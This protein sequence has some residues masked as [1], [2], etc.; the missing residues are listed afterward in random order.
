MITHPLKIAILGGGVFGR[1]HIQKA[2]GYDK[3]GHICLFEPDKARAQAM[4]DEF[5]IALMPTAQAAIDHC[6]AVVI[7]APAIH[8]AEL[9]HAALSAG[10]HCLIEKPIAH[11]L[12]DAQAICDMA[13]EKGLTVHMGHQERYVLAAIGI[14]TIVPKPRLIEMFRENLFSERGTDVSAT[15]DLTVHDLD[16]VMWLLDAQPLGIMATGDVV[17]TSYIDQ[18]RAVLLFD[19]TKVIIHT[20][21]VALTPRRSMQLS[22]D[23]G[24]IDID[25]NARSLTHKT[26]FMLN[27]SF[28]ND[29]RGQDALAA[30]DYAFYDAI[31][32]GAP[33]A[34]SAKDG[35]RA[36]E[37][38][39]DIDA[40]ILGAQ[41]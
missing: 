14:D 16:M 33:P 6:D 13:D 3:I 10:K 24:V 26:P 7:T 34:I 29:P 22:Y 35:L 39:L 1:Y 30:S 28:A 9:A 38:A 32:S 8:H 4:A 36:L 17:K 5:D 15:L 12:K 18:S 31:L 20:S 25:F 37:W 2:L 23:E 21:R 40:L 11:S 27:A 41:S 19:N